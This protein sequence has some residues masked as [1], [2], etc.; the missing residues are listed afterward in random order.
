MGDDPPHMPVLGGVPTQ[1]HA[2]DHG[3]ASPAAIGK[4]LGL[5]YAGDGDVGRGVQ[6][7]G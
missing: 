7:D 5:I 6:R 1:G 3:E 4:D 2:T